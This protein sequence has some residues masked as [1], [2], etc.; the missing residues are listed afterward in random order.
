MARII[1]SM[2]LVLCGSA[3]VHSKNGDFDLNGL[4]DCADVDALVAD[5]ADG[6]D[7]SMFDLFPA[8]S[9]D[10]YVNFD[11]L[12]EWLRLAGRQNLSSGN[13]YILGDANLDGSVDVSDFNV[14]QSNFPPP[15]TPGWCSGDFTA[16]GHVD[17]FDF[18]MW[19]ANRFT[20]SDTFSEIPGF[21]RAMNDSDYVS[22]FVDS[23]GV[24]LAPVGPVFSASGNSLSVSNIPDR[25]IAFTVVADSEAVSLAAGFGDEDFFSQPGSISVVREG[26]ANGRHQ[27]ARVQ[28]VGGDGWQDDSMDFAE[29]STPITGASVFYLLDSG[30]GSRG[31]GLLVGT[32]TVV[33]PEPGS[34]G[35]L[36]MSFGLLTISTRRKLSSSLR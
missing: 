7:S 19:R 17:V 33:V 22:L 23:L 21:A 24:G 26:Y 18:V 32:T 14:W 16:D 30:A 10:G 9:P 31:D 34:A 5:I 12:T 11:D 36:A 25:L 13:S 6:N 3:A 4:L 27:W 20:S 29:F 2:I 35:L 28:V 15:A 1:F 8:G